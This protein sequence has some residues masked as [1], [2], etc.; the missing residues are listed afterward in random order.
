MALYRISKW[1]PILA[2]EKRGK[3]PILKLKKRK[4]GP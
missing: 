1:Q 4:S 3:K 2:T